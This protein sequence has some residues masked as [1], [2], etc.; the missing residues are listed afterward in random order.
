MFTKAL[1]RR[2]LC[3]MTSA[4]LA[5][6]M[7]AAIPITNSNNALVSR[8]HATSVDLTSGLPAPRRVRYQQLI[9]YY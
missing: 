6:E 2:F 1:S 5:R 9:T 3:L 4:I 7:F 8:F